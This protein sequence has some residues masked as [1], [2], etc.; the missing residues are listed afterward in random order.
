MV[1]VSENTMSKKKSSPKSKLCKKKC[2][3]KSCGLNKN[4][5]KKCEKILPET[6]NVE[7]KVKPPENYFLRLIK[8]VFG[9]E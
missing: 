2:G 6:Q 9:Y 5:T 1:T 8:K 3:N 7:I 4:T